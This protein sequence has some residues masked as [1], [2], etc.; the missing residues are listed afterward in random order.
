MMDNKEHLFK[1]QISENQKNF[2]KKKELIDLFRLHKEISEKA[3]ES[4][5]IAENNDLLM[6]SNKYKGVNQQLKSRNKTY[7]QLHNEK[8]F[9]DIYSAFEKFLYDHLH[10]LYSLFP[11]ICFVEDRLS[12][13]F[14]DIFLSDSLENSQEYI[15]QETIKGIIQSNTI[16]KAIGTILDKIQI[17]KNKQDILSNDNRKLLLKFSKIRNLIIHNESLMNKIV[18]EELKKLDIQH[19]FIEYQSVSEDL[20]DYISQIQ[21]L[22]ESISKKITNTLLDKTSQ[23]VNYDKSK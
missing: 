20:D 3:F 21:V 19:N 6:L 2:D 14:M 23:L 5:N 18:L 4:I 17:A 12:V 15:I 13:R 9:V 10:T 16:D 8:V 7:E 22:F 11:K 1:A